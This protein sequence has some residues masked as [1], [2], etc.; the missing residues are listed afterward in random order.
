M[1]DMDK[2]MD[3]LI[4]V[5]TKGTDTDDKETVVDMLVSYLVT[6]HK[7]KTNAAVREKRVVPK[8]MDEYD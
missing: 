2:G 7:A 3:A 6:H 8:V 1:P 4:D 5:A